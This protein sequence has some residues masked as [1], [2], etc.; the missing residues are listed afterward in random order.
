[1]LARLRLLL[2][3]RIVSFLAPALREW[4]RSVEVADRRV[5]RYGPQGSPDAGVDAF[6]RARAGGRPDQRARR[7]GAV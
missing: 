3:R 6:E 7:T 2:A 1:M 5:P 4:K